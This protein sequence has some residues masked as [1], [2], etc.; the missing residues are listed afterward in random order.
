MINTARRSAAGAAA[1]LALA[2]ACP[3]GAALPEPVRAMV[4]AALATGDEAKVRTVI[5]IARTTNP[6]DAAELAAIL[7][8][9][10]TR[11]A[12][13]R[14]AEAANKE[15][16]L[17]SAGMFEH[18]TGRAEFGGFRSTGNSANTGITASLS[19]ERKGVDW[20]HK[21]VARTDYQR[22]NGTTTR[23]QFLAR[24][25]PNYNVSP[26]IYVYALAQFERDRFQGFDARYAASGGIGYQALKTEDLQLSIK[27]GPAYRVTRFTGGGSE[28][29]LAGLIGLDFG[30]SIT[31]RL[32]LTQATNAV[33]ETGGS[34]VAI[35][36]SRNTSVDLLT[37]LNARISDKLSA[38]FSHSWEYDSNPPAGAVGTDTLTRMTLVYGF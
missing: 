27:A 31:D 4:D 32:K 28:N 2:A 13:A 8:T 10:E 35:V 14:A 37:A 36:D 24:Y 9:F 7:K 5:E 34:A 20:R 6:G 1:C 23:E 22:A 25:E 30:W 11:L 38:R 3:A 33:A 21:V 18:W 19:A 16:A 17:R 26:D 12:D 15:A 29:R